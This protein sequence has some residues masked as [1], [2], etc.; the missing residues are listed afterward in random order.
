[1]QPGDILLTGRKSQ[2]P[3]SLAIKLGQRLRG[4]APEHRQFS[5]A[6]LVVSDH[7]DIVEAEAKGV[8]R[9]HVSKYK[10]GDY[11]IIPVD[12]GPLDRAQVLEFA[13]AV[14]AAR[15]KY[16]YWTF[17]SLVIFCATAPVPFIPTLYV[18]PAGTAICSGF[19]ADAL[20][21]AGCIWPRP[22]FAMMPAD[23]AQHFN[24]T[25]E[26]S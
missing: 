22:A 26:P 1:M 11:A 24:Y 16:G 21:R 20:T 18:E 19:V 17:A 4:Y 12:M 13:D 6:A 23:L 15:T 10:P 8:V 14:V 3:V 7:G 25:E 9:S 5:H 2:G